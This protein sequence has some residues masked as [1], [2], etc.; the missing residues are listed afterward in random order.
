MLEN[1]STLIAARIKLNDDDYIRIVI[2]RALS[3]VGY[4][5]QEHIDYLSLLFLCKSVNIHS[6][7]TVD[8]L[9]NALNYWN[10]V[11]KAKTISSI[12]LL[13]SLGCLD[14]NIGDPTERMA[15]TYHLPKER[16]KEI[17]P[18]MISMLA[19]DYGPS[20]IGVVLAIVNIERKTEYKF[21][22]EKWIHQ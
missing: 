5:P 14:L 11:F 17:C 4:L 2:D 8:D 10:N 16:V 6:I 1:L 12:S 20:Q 18:K 19:P 22:L 13:N 9:K 7:K 3:A 21:V 15:E